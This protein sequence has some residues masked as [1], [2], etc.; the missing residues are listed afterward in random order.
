VRLITAEI[1]D[2]QV[3]SAADL[4]YRFFSE[5]AFIAD[6]E[7]IRANLDA[8]RNDAHHWAAVCIMDGEI[9]G[10]VT[11]TTMLYVEWGRLGEIGDLYVLPEYR[12]KGILGL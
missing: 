8:L 11:V 10:I 4:L 2:S 1:A 3:V 9:V 7:L 6:R 12:T 5:E